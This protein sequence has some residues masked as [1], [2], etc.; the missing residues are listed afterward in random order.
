MNTCLVRIGRFVKL[1]RIVKKMKRILI[2][3]KS[4]EDSMRDL[5]AWLLSRLETAKDELK[6]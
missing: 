6:K 2:R 3:E 1:L 4:L 5:N